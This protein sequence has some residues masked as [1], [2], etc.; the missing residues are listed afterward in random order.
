VHTFSIKDNGIGID[1]SYHKK[2]FELFQ[3]L[4]V[5]KT[6]GSN[7]MGLAVVKK[8]INNNKGQIYL[9]SE[10]NVGS[11]FYFTLPA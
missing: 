10:I 3:K 8:I 1:E 6:N 7:G 5:E 2:I 11:T 9:K 4:K